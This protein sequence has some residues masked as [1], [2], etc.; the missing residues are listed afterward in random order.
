MDVVQGL[1]FE[2][3]ALV[4]G[5]VRHKAREIGD[6]GILDRKVRRQLAI[7]RG[8]AFARRPQLAMLPRGVLQRRLDRMATPQ[9]HM[10]VRRSAGATSA[11]HPSRASAQRFSVAAFRH[12]GF[13]A[14]AAISC[15]SS[16]L[17]R[18]AMAENACAQLTGFNLPSA[19]RT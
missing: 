16:A 14:S 13:P 19:P 17:M 6:F 9:P 11:L 7:E 5:V 3:E 10:P 1:A 18:S 2:H 4:R 15:G 12:A 8:D